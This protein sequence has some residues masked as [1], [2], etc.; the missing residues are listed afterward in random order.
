MAEMKDRAKRDDLLGLKV[1]VAVLGVLIL[2]G[3]ALVIGTVIARIYA[4]RPHA[5]T[6]VVA[7]APTAPVGAG[8]GGPVTL[9]PGE[10]IAGIAA[11]GQDL[12]VWI[13]APNGGRVELID[14]ATGATRTVV[15][16]AP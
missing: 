7:T 5:P 3:T 11:V 14:P 8:R 2:A 1:V 15:G 16:A 4:K 6:A 13:D 12:A 9:A 10:H